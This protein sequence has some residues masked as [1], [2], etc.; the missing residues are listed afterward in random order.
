[1]RLLRILAL[2]VG[3]L[4]AAALVLAIALLV[5]GWNTLHARQSHPVPVLR[6]QPADSLIDRGRHL[7]AIQ[8]ASCHGQAGRLPLSGGDS[9][10]LAGT[11]LGSLHAPNLTPAGVLARYGDG[12]LARA[13]RE[14]VG[15]DGRAL[16][17]MPSKD[18]RV[19]SDRDLAALIAYLRSQPAVSREVPERKLTPAAYLALGLRLAET[20]V[21][22]PVE[23]AVPHPEEGMTRAYGEYLASYL[24]CRSCH[25]QALDGR[26]REPFAP[27]GPGLVSLVAAHD[28]PDFARAVREGRG[29]ADGRGIP[30]AAMPWPVYASLTDTEVGALYALL[31]S[32]GRR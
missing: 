18:S 24:G 13:I 20:S 27:E 5:N 19:L 11:P 26:G 2:S 15:R 14:G 22:H 4:A 23:T 7:A 25:G 6:I 17:L 16:L 28:L 9:D 30:A 29:M 12:E 21:Q 10:L 32:L 1:M 31:Q 3:T 8:C